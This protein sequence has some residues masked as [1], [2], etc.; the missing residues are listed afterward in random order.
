MRIRRIRETF[1]SDVRGGIGVGGLFMVAFLAGA[2]FYVSSLASTINQR[3]GM[4]QSADASAFAES[5][6]A[7]RGMNMIS[8][9][10]VIMVAL[11]AVELPIRAM[12]PS[13]EKV[14]KMPCAD[15]CSCQI[16]ADAEKA[17]LQLKTLSQTTEQRIGDLL[18]ALSEAQ[19]AIAETSPKVGQT[20]ANKATTDN[21]EFLKTPQASIY[22]SS[23]SKQGCR[24]GLPVEEDTFTTVCK[25]AKKY[26]AELATKLA[27]EK[28]DTMK[29]SCK[30]GPLAMADASPKFPQ[31]DTLFCTEAKKAPCSGSGPHPKKV[32]QG[33]SN[34][35]DEMQF[36]SQ[37]G[38]RDLRDASGSI[39][40]FGPK[41]PE[42]ADAKSD[43]AF[44]Q[45]EVYFDCTGEFSTCNKDEQAMYDT[46]WTAR[47]RRISKPTISFSG[48][49]TVKND[50]ADPTKWQNARKE[51][52][53]KRK[54][55]FAAGP[56]TAAGTVLLSSTEGPLQ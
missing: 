48:D 47:L 20:S 1:R 31:A 40:P 28:L 32:V 37:V 43:V 29:G 49:S 13:Y 8:S 55:V 54:T 25:R 14:A 42:K 18:T 24:P 41:D 2:T 17:S 36:W 7:A 6:V 27:D 19:T 46:Q 35:S 3:D 4:Q 30:S 45:S 22:S 34:G 33:A 5:V 51:L 9:M 16:K 10:N 26:T 21:K 52:F 12:S 53:E 15:S 44:A 23:L 50:I 38:G 56:K 39:N 11:N